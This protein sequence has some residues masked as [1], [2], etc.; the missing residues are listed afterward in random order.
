VNPTQLSSSVSQLPA[1]RARRNVLVVALADDDLD[2][3]PDGHVLVV[4]PAL[5]S[6]L[7]R[8]LSDEDPA[9]RRAE[10][11]VVGWLDRLERRGVV[12]EGR[13]GDADPLRAIADAL[14]TFPADEIVLAADPDCPPP[15]PRPLEELVAR[16]RER[17]PR[18]PV[19][20]L[21]RLERAA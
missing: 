11:R 20:A 4:A 13:I 15:P 5:N 14:A 3:A 19:R 7:R 8:W 12:A 6:W 1:G 9:R 2:D 10:R 21:Q 17:F 18:V 16:A